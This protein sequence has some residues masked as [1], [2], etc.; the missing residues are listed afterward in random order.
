[1]KQGPR[2]LPFHRLRPR[3]GASPLGTRPATPQGTH[4]TRNDVSRAHRAGPG[5]SSGCQPTIPGWIPVMSE[6]SALGP[7][8]GVAGLEPSQSSTSERVVMP[9]A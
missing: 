1:M 5:P 3:D 4:R 7:P 9:S 2:W 6:E 8:H